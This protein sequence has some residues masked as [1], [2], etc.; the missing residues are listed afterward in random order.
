M[1]LGSGRIAAGAR[2]SRPG[3]G[4]DCNLRGTARRGRLR[5]DGVCRH[6]TDPVTGR[7]APT[8][9]TEELPGDCHTAINFELFEDGVAK[10]ELR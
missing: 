6:V 5:Y 4:H 3:G 1:R 7:L 2:R 10:M 9:A 8:G